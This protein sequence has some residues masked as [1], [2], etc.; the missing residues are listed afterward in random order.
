LFHAKLAAAQASCAELCAVRLCTPA[1]DTKSW[2]CITASLISEEYKYNSLF[3]STILVVKSE[4]LAV[5][6]L[7]PLVTSGNISSSKGPNNSSICE[8]ICFFNSSSFKVVPA[9]SFDHET[10]SVLKVSKSTLHFPVSSFKLAPG[11]PSLTI[12]YIPP[13]V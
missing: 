5:L 7:I 12:I 13:L 10:N 9:S 8:N 3:K 1:A 2:P 11:V 4:I 6:S